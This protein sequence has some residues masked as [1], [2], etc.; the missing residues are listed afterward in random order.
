LS[1]LYVLSV[2]A[3]VNSAWKSDGRGYRSDE[4]PTITKHARKYMSS[5]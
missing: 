3:D 2:A 1:K 4:K 5:I